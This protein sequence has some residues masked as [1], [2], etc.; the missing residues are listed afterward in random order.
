MALTMMIAGP[1]SAVSRRQIESPSSPGSI[2][3]STT[4][5]IGAPPSTLSMA[6]ASPATCTW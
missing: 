6:L 3:S 1:P 4:R 5:S 2:R